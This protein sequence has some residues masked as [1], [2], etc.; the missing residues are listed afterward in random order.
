M[1]VPYLVNKHTCLAP[2]FILF[3]L[4]GC[5]RPT[6]TPHSFKE[7]P[8]N[9]PTIVNTKNV[10]LKAKKL[11]RNETNALFDQRASRLLRKRKALYPLYLFIENRSEKA[12]LFD[13]HLVDLELTDPRIVASRLYAHTARRII[14]PLL[15][16]TTGATIAFI[17]AVYVTIIGAVGSIPAATKAGTALLGVTGGLLVGS[18]LFSYYQGTAA[19]KANRAIDKDLL[20]K[21]TTGPVILPPMSSRETLLFVKARNYKSSFTLKLIDVESGHALSFDI[22]LGKGVNH[23]M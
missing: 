8:I 12:L 23:D 19:R 5:K 18:P 22:D 1:H 10:L 7:H 15:I 2:L 3:F 20:E 21:S 17:G 11:T 13:T 9:A 16:G 6:Y 14:T 4:S